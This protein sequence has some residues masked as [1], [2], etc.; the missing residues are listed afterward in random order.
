MH[1]SKIFTKIYQKD[2][3]FRERSTQKMQKSHEKSKIDAKDGKFA[4]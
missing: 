3:D 1:F 4:G 2:P